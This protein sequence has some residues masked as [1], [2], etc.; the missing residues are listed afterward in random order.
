M[1]I[2]EELES[3]EVAFTIIL[4]SGN[5]RSLVHE[6]MASMRTKSFDVVNEKFNEADEELLKAH[7]AQTSLLHR[8]SQGDQLEVQIIM[9]HAQDHL[10]TTMTLMEVAKEMEFIYKQL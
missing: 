8:C 2:I 9:V 7:Q 5:A 6:A 3:Q 1:A 4:H 10:M